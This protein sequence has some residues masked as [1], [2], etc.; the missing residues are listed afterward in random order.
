MNFDLTTLLV[1]GEGATLG[2]WAIVSLLIEQAPKFGLLDRPND[3]SMHIRV[4]PRGGGIGIVLA[5]LVA[6]GLLP[7][8]RTTPGLPVVICLSS[9]LLI[10]AVSLR[11]DFKSLSAGVRFLCHLLLAGVVIGGTGYY[12]RASVPFGGIVDF[13]WMGVPLTVVWIVGLTNVYNFMDGID[14][15]AGVQGLTAGLAWMAAGWWLSSPA[16]ALL[17]TALAGGCLG[18]LIHNWPPARIF[19]GDVGSAFLGFLFALLPLVAL[20][21]PS[22]QGRPFE[23]EVLPVFGLL[24]VWPFVGDGFY[25]FVRRACRG[26]IVWKPHR[27]HLYQRLVAVGWRHSKV[28][29]LYAAWCGVSALVGLLWLTGDLSAGVGVAVVPVLTLAA[30]IALVAHLERRLARPGSGTEV[31][32]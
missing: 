11:D 26:E 9:A 2:A 8:F 17:G 28:S 25:T 19:M 31:K 14:G 20:R 12:R 23:A 18:F 29:S 16:V 27:A 22:L 4:T 15:I 13:G 24:V 32:P 6:P 21:E 1:I 30:M 3:R 7:A 10:A 5:V